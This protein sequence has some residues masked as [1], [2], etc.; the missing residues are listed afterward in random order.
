MFLFPGRFM[1]KIFIFL[2][3]FLLPFSLKANNFLDSDL[4]GVPDKDE[5]NIYFTDPNLRDTDYDGYSDW[6]EL[7][8]GFSPLDSRPIKLED[9]D[10]DH[11]G[12]SDRME[13]NF[14]TNLTN[15][16][17]DGDGFLDGE[18]IKN[19]YN[20]LSKEN[21][22]LEKRIEINTGKQELDYFL[23]GVKM[24][25]FIIS[26][27]VHGTTPLG[28][29]I[30]RNKSIKAWSPYGLWMPYW[31]GL[32]NGRVG[33]HELPVWPN[34]YVEGEDHLGTPVSHGCIRL[35]HDSAEFLYNWAEVGTG[36]FVY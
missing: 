11:D 12:L 34:G 2:F 33:I 1:K 10:F 17:T 9:S 36:V 6:L 24:G 25:T 4:D 16:D 18:E 3:I 26:S 29:H 14:K 15:K 31:L 21:K 28:Q 13:L 32:D 22:K 7:N 27:G 23:G 19:F 20:P 35:G 30:I 8:S 5:I